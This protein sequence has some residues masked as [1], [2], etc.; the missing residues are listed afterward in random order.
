MVKI[1][2]YLCG[3]EKAEMK[4]DPKGG[5]EDE[6]VWCQT[7]GSYRLTSKIKRYCFD[8]GSLTEEDKKKLSLRV[9]K[10]YDPEKSDGHVEI[11]REMIKEETGKEC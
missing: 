9:Q 10:D 5:G 6:L 11:T 1:K 2:C 8:L 3:N 7:C 4:S